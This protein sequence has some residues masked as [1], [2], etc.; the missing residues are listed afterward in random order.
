M[1]HTINP[2]NSSGVPT[3]SWSS[4]DKPTGASTGGVYGGYIDTTNNK[5]WLF[6]NQRGAYYK[7]INSSGVPTGSWS[8]AD[9]PSGASNVYSGFVDTENNNIWITDVYDGVYYKSITGANSAWSSIVSAT[10]LSSLSS[11]GTVDLDRVDGSITASW[12]AATDTNATGYELQY[13]SGASCTP[14]TSIV[15]P[16]KTIT[17]YKIKSD[18]TSSYSFRHKITANSNALDSAWSTTQTTTS[19]DIRLPSVSCSSY[20]STSTSIKLNWTAITDTK[21]TG[22]KVQY[23]KGST[24]TPNTDVVIASRAITTTTIR[25]LDSYSTY[26]VRMKATASNSNQDSNWSDIL[27]IKTKLAAPGGLSLNG[28]VTATTIPIKWSSVTN[29]NGYNAS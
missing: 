10:G 5:L 11:P 25:N 27:K 4:A 12:T 28:N 20:S 2:L 22:Y 3:G 19:A 21:A 9:E 8:S 24:C 15:I 23:C 29:A 13:C 26:S 6:D 17:S 1:E 16:D 18:A 14:N 7:S